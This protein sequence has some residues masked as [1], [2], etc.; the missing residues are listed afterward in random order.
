MKK[1]I[2]IGLVLLVHIH[3]FISCTVTIPRQ[4]ETY[5]VIIKPYHI[6]N[7]MET[8][9]AYYVKGHEYTVDGN[10]RSYYV[11]G[12]KYKLLYDS[13]NPYKCDVVQNTP[14]FLPSEKTKKTI[15]KVTCLG[16]YFCEYEYNDE[17]SDNTGADFYFKRSQD[18]PYD[19]K[20][21]YPNL[22]LGQ[23][24]LVEYWVNDYRRSIIYL[25]KPIGEKELL[26]KQ[27]S[28]DSINSS[29]Y[30]LNIISA[31]TVE[32]LRTVAGSVNT[33][34]HSKND[35]SVNFEILPYRVSCYKLVHLMDT[36]EYS[37]HKV[38]LKQ[39]KTGSIIS[40]DNLFYTQLSGTITMSGNIEIIT[41][42][43][44]MKLIDEL[45]IEFSTNR[46]SYKKEGIVRKI[47]L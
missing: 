33:Y 26:E 28:I 15:G 13:L 3:F 47:D 23:E 46:V 36:D 24:Y 30:H 41:R 43:K 44:D 16:K 42:D 27:K 29:Q 8:D 34:S 18:L 21:K 14:L 11:K 7:V 39:P 40:G 38:T 10:Y 25:D 22:K 32:A 37:A 20:I 45:Y 17:L 2:I 35:K 12:E 31:G 4:K 1:K 6:S 5:A 9:F 19:Y